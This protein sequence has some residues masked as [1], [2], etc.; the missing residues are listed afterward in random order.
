[1]A[2]GFMCVLQYQTLSSRGIVHWRRGWLAR[3][4]CSL[5]PAMFSLYNEHTAPL[6]VRF[7]VKVVGVAIF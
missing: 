5:E 2:N 7:M 3:L 4:V 6:I 1:M